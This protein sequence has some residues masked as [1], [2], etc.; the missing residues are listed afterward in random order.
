MS[1]G[2]TGQ[3]ASSE[4]P[5][6][7]DK[8]PPGIRDWSGRANNRVPHGRNHPEQRSR[9]LSAMKAPNSSVFVEE[10]LVQGG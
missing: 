8:T 1:K 5:D 4:V 2:G 9:E 7:K 10:L 6:F 3:Q